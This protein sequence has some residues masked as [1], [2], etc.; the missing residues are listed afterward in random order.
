MRFDNSELVAQLHAG[1]FELPWWSTFLD[2]LR[3]RTKA[4]YVGLVFRMLD[5][6]QQVELSSG[7]KLPEHLQEIFRVKL[8]RARLPHHEMREGRVYALEELIDVDNPTHQTF[9]DELLQPWGVTNIRSVYVAEPGGVDAWLT[10]SGG[11]HIG[12]AVSALLAMLVPHLRIALR[13]LVTLER[14]RFRAAVTTDAFHRISFGWLTLDAGCRIVEMTAP[15]EAMFQRSRVLQRGRYGRLTPSSPAIDREITA[16]IREFAEDP[17]TRPRAINLSRD[18]QID[19][20]LRPVS[21]G[22]I[23]SRNAPVAI[24]YISGDRVSAAD[25]CE[26]LVDLFGLLPSEARLAWAI[27][28]GRSLAEA[29][30]DLGL[31]IETVRNYS[32]KIYA[33]T[34][35]RGQA[36]LV[37]IILTSVLAFA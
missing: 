16:V 33:K 12:P 10:C 31:T 22:S 35:A 21:P 20:L 30:D 3:A 24:A 34:G 6:A 5:H 29:A 14:E 11:R 9:R 2:Q 15:M 27:A 28:Q 13:T 8:A 25:R 1:V 23:V 7:E 4:R 18:P 26:Q 32:K 19:M 17:E 37:R 36:E